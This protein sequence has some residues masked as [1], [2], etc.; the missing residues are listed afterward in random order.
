MK[1]FAVVLLCLIGYAWSESCTNSATDC[2]HTSCSDGWEMHCVDAVCTCT[3]SN[4]M[5]C[6]TL[7]DCLDLNTWDCPA[8]RRH[9][10]DNMCRCTRF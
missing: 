4:N 6:N 5:Q 1:C 9:C 2:V 3:Q 10:I 8:N 7:Q